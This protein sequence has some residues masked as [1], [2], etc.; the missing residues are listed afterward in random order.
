MTSGPISACS[1]TD[2]VHDGISLARFPRRRARPGRH[3]RIAGVWS[4]ELGNRRDV[5]VFL[6]PSYDDGG[7]FP[8]VYLHDGQNLFD[9]RLSFAGSWGADAAADAAAR[10]GY[11][12]ILVGIAN[13]NERRVHEYSPF[14]DA[15]VGGGAGERYLQFLIRTVKPRIDADYRTRPGREETVIGGASLGGLISLYAFFRFPEIFGRA[16]VQS[17]ALWFAGGAI[18]D[19]VAAA[20]AVPGRIF[21]D[22]GGKEGVG[23]LRNARRMRDLLRDKG[24]EPGRTLHYLEQRTGKHHEAAWG[25]RLKRALPFLLEEAP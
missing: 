22:V 16:S 20:S 1:R 21:L 13:A 12:A 3:V 23:T 19:Y 9:P 5:F 18:F 24:Y 14:V 4:P 11:E 10:L 2:G 6:P 7:H 25:R 8:V 17:P 15:K